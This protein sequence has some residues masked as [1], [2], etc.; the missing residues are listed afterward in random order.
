MAMRPNDT[1]HTT[2]RKRSTD[3]PHRPRRDRHDATDLHRRRGGAPAEPLTRH[4]LPVRPRRRD[5]RRTGRPSLARRRARGST[6]GWTAKRRWPNARHTQNACG[7]LARVVPRPQQSAGIEDLQDQA[8]GGDVPRPSEHGDQPRAPTS[9]HTPGACCSATTPGSGWRRG[10]CR[11]PP[12][13]GTRSIMR[14][15]VLAKWESWPLAKI[16]HLSVQGWITDLGGR[17]SPATLVQCRRLMSGVLRSAV[18]NRLIVANP[19]DGVRI[20]ARRRQDT[21][22][23]IIDRAVFRSSLLPVVPHRYRALVGLGGGAGLRW[24]EAVGLCD[25][26]LDLDAATPP[27]RPDGHRGRWPHRVQALPEDRGGTPLGAAPGLAGRPAARARR[28]PTRAGRRA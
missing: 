12:P 11:R 1:A 23:Q 19:C 26:A 20:P 6:P 28:R 7:D 18:R 2:P 13:P 22:D 16:D 21:D 27:R 25:D 24:G 8:R 15:H 9:P 17:L 4:H 5:P 3:D 14:N 10:T